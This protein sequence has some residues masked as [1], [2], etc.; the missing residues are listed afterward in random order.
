[1]NAIDSRAGT[2]FPNVQRRNFPSVYTAVLYHIISIKVVDVF[3]VG[4]THTSTSGGAGCG[5]RM[6]KML[7]MVI[8]PKGKLTIEQ[9]DQLMSGDIAR[10]PTIEA[11]PPGDFVLRRDA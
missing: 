10:I 9:K 3:G 8:A 5:P 11:K 2:H 4:R 1:M 6:S 7:M